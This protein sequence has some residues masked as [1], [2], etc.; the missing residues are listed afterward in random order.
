M[1]FKSIQTV[2]A[3]GCRMQKIELLMPESQNL[4]AAD[5]DF[6]NNSG[7]QSSYR[8]YYG[9]FKRHTRMYVGQNYQLV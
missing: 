4:C 5:A 6:I 9:K 7:Q 2:Q 3:S 8:S 1:L